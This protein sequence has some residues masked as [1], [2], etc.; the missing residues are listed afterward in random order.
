M[1]KA[2]M[3]SRSFN[4][5]RFLSRSGAAVLAFPM[6][7]TLPVLGAN[8][9]L[10][11]AGIGVGGKGWTDITMVAS[12]NIVALCDVDDRRAA[13]AYKRFPNAKRFK[14]YRK[15]FDA[16][17]HEIDAV[18]VTTPDHMHFPAS[19]HAIHLGK[20]VYCQKPLTHSVW[21][22]R[23][24]TLAARKAKVAT[25]MG[26]QGM[27]KPEVRRD[28][29]LIKA[30]AIGQVREYHFWTD[31]PGQWWGQAK[32]RPT[33][34]PP[35]PAELDWELWLGVAPWR[36]YHP[37]YVPFTWRGFW[38]FGT[39]A[40]GDMGC[41]L[42]NLAALAMD[43]S[44]P[45]AVEAVTKDA[46]P[47][48]G[49]AWSHVMWEFP[50]RNGREAFRLFWYDGGQKP[51]Q[52]LFPGQK[53]PENGVIVVG[54]DDVMFVGTYDG[55]G[56]LRSGRKYS[57]F[58]NAPE[59]YEK[60]SDWEPAHYRE[61]INAAKGGPAGKSNFEVAGPVS[62]TVLLGNIAIRTG[63]RVEWDSKNLRVTNMDAASLVKPAHRHGWEV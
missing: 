53:Y 8:G 23:T 50:A 16:I 32:P 56:I 45:T 17:G 4:R 54:S 48:T 51:S 43:V 27:A 25:Q 30:G 14:D 11:I 26:N 55:G 24:L 12:E 9:R 49:P 41:H 29:E 19:M 60:Y 63:R 18:T 3:N 35:V 52:A 61:W 42:L 62:E 5:R 28:A 44:A 1:I 57:D 15:M 39:G 40:L 36:P 33:G 58:K 31:R 2:A 10:N 59:L 13:D 6:V 22:A 46:N 7:S 37:D 21:E 20:H 47:E 38:D 34:T